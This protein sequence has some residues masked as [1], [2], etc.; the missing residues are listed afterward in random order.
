MVMQRPVPFGWVL[1]EGDQ[2]PGAPVT[3]RWFADG[4]LRHVMQITDIEPRRLPP[5]RWLEHEVEIES[6]AR[7]TRVAMAGSTRELQAS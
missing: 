3:L 6:E 7:V 4:Q 1:V 2:G 5:G